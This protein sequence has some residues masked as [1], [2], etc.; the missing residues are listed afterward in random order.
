MAATL[1]APASAPELSQQPGLDFLIDAARFREQKEA[2]I[3]FD[4]I[5]NSAPLP[6]TGAILAYVFV[7]EITHLLEGVDSWNSECLRYSRVR[8]DR[9]VEI[10][11][12][13]YI[14]SVAC[15]QS[16]NAIFGAVVEDQS[17]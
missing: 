7:H 4:G 11:G 15:D 9:V 13:R 14:L 12:S 3:Y 17:K 16:P 8:S 10:C 6:N 2:A 1:A 5:R